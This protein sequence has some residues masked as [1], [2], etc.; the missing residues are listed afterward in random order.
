[1]YEIF[2][3]EN[4]NLNSMNPSYNIGTMKNNSGNSYFDYYTVKKGDN[5]YEIARKNDIEV[6]DL[7]LING[8]KKDDYIYPNQEILIP[9]KEYKIIITKD[10]DTINS[11]SKKLNISALELLKQNNTLYLLPEQLIIYRK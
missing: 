7:L 11:V 5:L 6:N 8:L 3:N 2:S 9:K 1:M 10:N 4:M